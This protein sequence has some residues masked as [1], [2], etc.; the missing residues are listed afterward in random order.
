MS[1]EGPEL[2]A[3]YTTAVYQS[4][5]QYQAQYVPTIA[6]SYTVS[7]K[8]YGEDIIGSPYTVEVLPGEISSSKSFTTVTTSELSDFRAGKTYRFTLS[9]VD[10]YGNSLTSGDEQIQIK[11]LA[12]YVNHDE[13]NSPVSVEDIPNWS[14]LYGMN[15]VGLTSDN[16]DGTYRCQLT[17]YRAGIFTLAVYINEQ[18][19][20]ASPWSEEVLV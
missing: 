18:H 10:I 14:Q 2:G 4:E 17:I 7:V 19:V 12:T 16:Q 9:L 1:M 15:I 20:E 5:G 3:Q 13:W 11:V 6:G 8:L